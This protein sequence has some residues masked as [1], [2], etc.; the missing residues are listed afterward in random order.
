[1]TC[2]VIVD[3]EDNLNF[4]ASFMSM[5]FKTCFEA[6]YGHYIKVLFF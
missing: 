1:M 2:R 3:M 4:M 6:W 5:G